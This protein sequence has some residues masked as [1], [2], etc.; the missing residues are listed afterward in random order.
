MK[1]TEHQKI[2]KQICD[3]IG[4][5]I[6]EPV[7]KEVADHLSACPSCQAQFDSIKKTVSLY[8]Q[9]EQKQ[10]MPNDVSLR[11]IKILHLDDI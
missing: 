1:E 8:R 2:V 7:C 3:F 9:V 11:L 10:T 4:E 5:D 6:D